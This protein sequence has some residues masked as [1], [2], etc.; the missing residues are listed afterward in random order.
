MPKGK[1]QQML[2][3]KF[4]KREKLRKLINKMKNEYLFNT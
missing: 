3:E 1:I 4:E 2:Q